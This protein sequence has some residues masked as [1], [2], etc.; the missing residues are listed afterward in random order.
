MHLQDKDKEA[1]I[2][3]IKKKAEKEAEFDT[4]N[5]DDIND[6][7]DDPITVELEELTASS[8]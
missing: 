1:I 2:D 6:I 5:T 4:V 8:I 7:E 3:A